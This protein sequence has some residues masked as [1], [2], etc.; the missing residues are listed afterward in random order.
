MS[1]HGLLTTVAYKLGSNAPA[2]YAL[3]G[4]VGVAGAAISWLRDNMQVLPDVKLSAELAQA[5]SPDG[6]VVF[7]PAFSG[8]YAPY[9]RNDARGYD[10]SYFILTLTGS[11]MHMG[12]TFLTLSLLLLAH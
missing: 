4:S 9:W 6:Q 12:T 5:A 8:L 10:L 3:E 2:M 11:T 1:T 7:V